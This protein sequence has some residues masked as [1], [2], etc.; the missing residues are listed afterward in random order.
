MEVIVSITYWYA[1]PI[2]TFVRVF[3][4]EKPSH[5]LP[6]YP[7]DRLIMQEVSYHLSIGFLIGL[8]RKKKVQWLTPIFWIKLYDIKSLKDAN[9][10]AKEIVGF[11][12]GTIS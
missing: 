11:K 8:Y 3:G 6:R 10:Q 1:S 7:I 9:T 12:L 5:F 4:G 2:G